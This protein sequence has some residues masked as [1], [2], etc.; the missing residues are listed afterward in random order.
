[1]L[2]NK[3]IR[4]AIA[5]ITVFVVVLLTRFWFYGSKSYLPKPLGYF[6]IELPEKKYQDYQTLCD[7][8][9]DIPTYAQVELFRESANSDTC[10]FNILYPRFN[11]RI[12]CTYLPVGNNFDV[13]VDDVNDI[14]WTHEA[15]ASA[16][17]STRISDLP[18]QMYG[19]VF[20]IEGDAA[21][22]TQFFLT[23]STKHFFRGA[24]YFYNKPNP[25]SIA[26]VLQFVRQDI[27]RLINTARWNRTPLQV[28]Q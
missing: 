15:R 12:H 4:F 5:L 21:S 22:Q 2:K 3:K 20:D 18:R 13:L 8:S 14:A 16:F 23:D 28:A 25:D 7:L 19:V 6:N 27:D 1:M 17:K 24:L 9:F 26:P 11:A 10:R